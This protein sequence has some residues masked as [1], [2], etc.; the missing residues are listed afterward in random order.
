MVTYG[1]DSLINAVDSGGGSDTFGD[2]SMDA[3]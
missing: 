3:T 1:M 2:D